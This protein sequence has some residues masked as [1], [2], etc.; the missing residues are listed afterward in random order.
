MLKHLRIMLVM[1]TVLI[2]AWQCGTEDETIVDVGSLS[3]KKS[4]ILSILKKKY[5]KQTD[6]SDVDLSIKKDLIEPLIAKK[7]RINAAYDLEL[8]KEKAF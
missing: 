4:E 2:F 7:L 5:P 6:F 1:I 8:D 3:I